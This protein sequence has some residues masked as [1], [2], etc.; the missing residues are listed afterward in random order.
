MINTPNTAFLRITESAYEGMLGEISYKHKDKQQSGTAYSSSE[1]VSLL[2]HI[3]RA[4][5]TRDISAVFVDGSHAHTVLTK[6]LDWIGRMENYDVYSLS[7]KSA[8]LPIGL[9]FFYFTISGITELN[10]YRKRSDIVFMSHDKCGDLF[11]LTVYNFEYSP[12]AHKAGG[13]IYHIFVDRFNRGSFK[14]CREDALY[15]DDWYSEIPEYPEYPGAFLRNNTFYG[16]NLYGIIDKLEYIKSLGVDTIYLSPIFEA[17][18]NHKYDTGDYSKVDDMF[19]GDKALTELIKRAKEYGIG[20]ILDGVF[21]HT[22]SDSVYFNKNG[23]Y[24]T[25]GAYQSQ[26]SKYFS[27]YNFENHPHKYESWWGIDIL[28]R[29]HPDTPACSDFFVGRDGIIEKYSALGIDGFRLDVADELPDTFIASIKSAL[30]NKNDHSILY[31]EVWEDASNKIAY[32]E[33]KKYYLGAELDG[34]MNYPIRTG[35]IE[36]IRD[37]STD[38]LRFALTEVFFNMPKRIRDLTMNLLGTHDTERILTVLGGESSNGKSNSEL[39]DIRMYDNTYKIATRRL[40][41]AY[42]ILSTLPGIPAIFYADE[43]GMEGYSDPFN[44]RTFPWGKENTEILNHYLKVGKNRTEHEVY[45]DGDFKLLHLDSE[46]LVYKRTKGDDTF[47][48]VYNNSNL[49]LEIK[50]S[51]KVK[52][53]LTGDSGKRH[54]LYNESAAIFVTK[55]KNTLSYNKKGAEI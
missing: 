53:I 44:R 29:I 1:A 15:I 23:R 30:N 42:T 48:T 3:P 28:P 7:V 20:I 35:I 36:Y 12:P 4:I 21:N 47:I 50:F 51:R 32:G 43:V 11:Q 22:G 27:W 45:K 52:E 40:K 55:T 2:L 54:L 13:I 41:A 17:Y 14:K 6:K 39:K 31:G 16:G 34:V 19:G 9:Y 8:V 49:P 10:G 24:S 37:K 46:L 26:D 5:G 38:S 18:S 33:R 25:L